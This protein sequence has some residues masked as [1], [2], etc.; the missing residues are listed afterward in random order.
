MVRTTRVTLSI[1]VMLAL[2]PVAAL[3]EGSS[4]IPSTTPQVPQRPKT[5]QE[6][7]IEHYN[8]GLQHRDRAWKL[9]EKANKA[10]NE[11]KRAKL[12]VKILDQY[13]SAIHQFRTATRNDPNMH[14]AHASL[15][16]ALRKTGNYEKSLQAYNTALKLAPDYTEAIEY[17]A[18]AYLGLGRLKEAKESYLRLFNLDRET[19]DTLL[20]AMKT[21]VEKRSSDPGGLSAEEVQE[22][23]S[24]VAERDELARQTASLSQQQTRKW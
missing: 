7:A 8:L 24:W 23:A 15:G 16:Y 22:F 6:Q 17:R 1:L 20:V 11:A 2:A 3:A 14:Q 4:P 21:W 13:E 18:E 19:A 10:P 12:Q 5:P 9:E